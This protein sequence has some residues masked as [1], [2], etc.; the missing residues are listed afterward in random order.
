MILSA[1]TS[2]GVT[3]E[4]VSRELAKL[5]EDL[6]VELE[7]TE[8]SSILCNRL[9]VRAPHEHVHRTF[10]DVRE[11]IQ[12]AGL[13]ERATTRS[14][15]A[16]RLLAEAEGLL[17]GDSPEEVAF[18][19]VGAVDSIAD[20]VG[21]CVALELLDIDSVSCGPLP[22]GT[23]TADTAH[24]PLPLP[25]PATVEILKGCPVRWTDEPHERTTPTGAALMHA[26]TGGEFTDAAPPM[27]IQSVGYG[28]GHSTLRSA[29][30]LLRA[31]LGELEG[32]SGEVD[33]LEA[34]IDDAGGELLGSAAERLLEEG[35]LD[36]WLEPVY[37]K[38][39]RGAYKLCAL[40]PDGER[41]SLSRL[42][43]RETGTLGVRHHPVGRTVAGRR[44]EEVQLSYGVCRVK[45][46][47]LDGEVLT[48]SPEHSDALRLARKNRLPLARVYEDVRAAFSRSG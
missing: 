30:N 21:S 2:A 48:A 32:P 26:F 3:E 19:E 1:L 17:H 6:G 45:V 22:M 16:F 11:M 43:L 14:L 5:G 25:A 38:R 41:E 9:S 31:V 23:G 13:P 37:M 47:E 28:A 8:V 10:A 46:G 35:A 7:Q 33:L 39:G 18:H 12:K 27:I 29:P 36:A 40:A 34:N 4:D 24:G 42:L 20:I 44:T 15:A